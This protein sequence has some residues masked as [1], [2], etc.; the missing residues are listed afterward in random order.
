MYAETGLH[1]LAFDEDDGV[2]RYEAALDIREAL[3]RPRRMGAPLCAVFRE[4]R[5]AL[6]LRLAAQDGSE[7]KI[8]RRHS[9]SVWLDAP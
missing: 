4:L 6:A 7:E 3:E 2:L 8:F 9:R 5:K 1:A